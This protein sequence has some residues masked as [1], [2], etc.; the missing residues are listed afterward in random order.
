MLASEDNK[1]SRRQALVGI[2]L[3]GAA[4]AV[5]L[6][7]AIASG[8]DRSAWDAAVAELAR[9]QAAADAFTTKVERINDAFDRLKS[10]VPHVEVPN[11]YGPP[12]SKTSTAN[13][14]HVQWARG[15]ARD[16]RYLEECAYETHRSEM[17]L[18]DAA[19]AREAK[20]ARID[21]RLGY[22][23]SND[24]HDALCEAICDAEQ[25]LLNIPAPDGDALLWKINKLYQPGSGMWASGFE[26]QT[27][28]DLHR[29][30]SSGRA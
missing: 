22:S 15:S 8:V 27:V 17:A 20:I 21:A 26:E 19:N 6:S 10:K 24:H 29:F 1:L 12:S 2:G 5:P 7:G 25:R 13:H 28:A 23:A 9:A 30:L 14:H 16:V 11:P 3:A 18:V 4:V